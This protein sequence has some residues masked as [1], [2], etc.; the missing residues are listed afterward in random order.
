MHAV[1]PR[2]QDI[3]TRPR[4][5][6]APIRPARRPATVVPDILLA[7]AAT[8]WTMAAV[9]LLA[10]FLGDEVL[11]GDAGRFLGRL[12]A[13]A[14]ALSALLLF[15]LGVSLLRDER[16]HAAHYVIPMGVGIAIGLLESALFLGSGGALMFAPFILL[17]LVIRPLR[18][19]FFRGS[20]STSRPR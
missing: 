13:G 2:P 6:N 1:Y 20:R 10:T 15:L 16:S 7:V 19:V 11:T 5:N 8:G 4:R 9:I 17:V 3:R 18:H 14:L 12:F